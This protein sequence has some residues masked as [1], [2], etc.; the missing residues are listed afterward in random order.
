M[1]MQKMEDSSIKF[2]VADPDTSLRQIVL[3]VAVT[4]FSVNMVIEDENTILKAL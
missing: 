1:E 3:Q 2:F 4:I